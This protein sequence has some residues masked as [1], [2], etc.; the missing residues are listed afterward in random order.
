MTGWRGRRGHRPVR[1][2]AAVMM[3][4]TGVGLLIG[5]CF[6]VQARADEP[7]SGWMPEHAEIFGRVEIEGTGFFEGA[8]FPEQVDQ[9]A[10]IAIEATALAEWNDGDTVFTLT[11]FARIDAQDDARSHFD[12]RDFKIE[13][14]QGDWAV[15]FGV[16]REFWGRTEVVHLVDIVNQTD[17]V[18]DL[19]DEDRLGQPLLKVSRLFDLGEVS[20]YYFPYVRVRTLPGPEGRLRLPVPFNTN[21]EIFET[22][23]EEWTPS[24]AA[25]Y[26]G[27]FGAV[28]VGLSAFHG[29]SRDPSFLLQAGRL[30]PVYSRI[31]QLGLDAQYTSGATLWKG[32]AIFREG[33]RNAAFEQ[34]IFGAFTGGFEHT[35]FQV[36]DTDAD[37]GLILEGAY[38]SRGDDAL[39]VFDNDVIVG[40][41]LTLNDTQDTA[42]LLTSA[43]DVKTAAT[44]LR[45]E[46]ERRLSQNMTAGLEAQ[47]FINSDDDFFEA[48]LADDSFVRLKLNIF[49]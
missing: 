39:T 22:S 9:G 40:A 12:L 41:R 10:S 25:R 28:D 30:V 27:V 21:T 32:E 6:G 1:T 45:L 3:M 7:S 48:G 35:L 33:Q 38:D 26:V 29:V 15:T 13:H 11:P 44:T 34:E 23:A 17:A 20:L 2:A 14:V 42:L 46:A 31:T 49:F 18:E 4:A 36:A 16:D 19:D 47:G 5:L 8:A 37:L 43:I 24:F